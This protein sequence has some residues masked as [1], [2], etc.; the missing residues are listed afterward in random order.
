MFPQSISTNFNR[1][2]CPSQGK[3]WSQAISSNFSSL[4]TSKR[5]KIAKD[6]CTHR[7]TNP[8]DALISTVASL[9]SLCG[10]TPLI[11]H[12]SQWVHL[13][14][15]EFNN[16]TTIYVSLHLSLGKFPII[17]L[18]LSGYTNHMQSVSMEI[19]NDIQPELCL[20]ISTGI[21]FTSFGHPSGTGVET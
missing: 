8:F 14:S 5:A 11:C 13:L 6:K 15:T 3:Y 16:G 20:F 12:I 9:P 1:K 7:S 10:Y 4:F 21:S 18:S 19:F 2:T 17:K